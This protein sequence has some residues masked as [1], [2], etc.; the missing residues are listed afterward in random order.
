MGYV[1]RC[2]RASRGHPNSLIWPRICTAQ[3]RSPINIAFTG[4][5]RL[6]P[7]ERYSGTFAPSLPQLPFGLWVFVAIVVWLRR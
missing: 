7:P 3:R 1:P 4:H 6:T 2:R 5:M